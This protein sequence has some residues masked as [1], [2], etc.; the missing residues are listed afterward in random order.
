MS[1]RSIIKRLSPIV[2][3]ALP[4]IVVAANA[5]VVE[6]SD[7]EIQQR[8]QRIERMLDSQ[9]LLDLYSQVQR[10]QSQLQELRGEIDT[11]RHMLDQMTARQKDLYA[12]I[13]RRLQTVEETG[14][15]TGDEFSTEFGI[16]DTIN[17]DSEAGAAAAGGESDAAGGG[18]EEEVALLEPD[19]QQ[20][21]TA[22]NKA[23]NFLKEGKYQEASAAFNEYLKKYPDS[24]YSDNAH[25]WLGETHYVTRD[26]NAAVTA[27]QRLIDTYP[28][29]Q[30]APHAMLKIGYSQQELG[31]AEQARK[32]L[33]DLRS[34]YPNSTAASLA[35]ERL[36]QLQAAGS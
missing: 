17:M 1:C 36:Q 23:F 15:G 3:G 24:E 5:P 19:Q 16:D 21:R 31:N 20:A 9:S 14:D 12:D 30:K 34:Q 22:Y 28:D 10:L 18:D 6:I 4:G 8:L 27:Y 13:D 25:Y 35:Q 7:Q 26:F 11:Q 2:I 29:S 32:I 33:Q